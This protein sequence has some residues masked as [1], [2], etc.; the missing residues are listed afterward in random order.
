MHTA[1]NITDILD[2]L[3]EAQYF[4]VLDLASGFQ[5]IETHPE[6]RV[7]TAFST[8]QGNFEYLRMPIGIKNAPA[9]F[10]RLTDAVLK[11]MHGTEVF[12]YLDDMVVHSKDLEEHDLKI[13]R[14]LYRLRAASQKLQPDKCE[15]LQKEVAYLGH[16]IGQLGLNPNPAKVEAIK[17]CPRPKPERNIRQFL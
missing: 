9:I 11:G 16:I 17:N 13:R 6:D 5:Q 15:F 1:P 4:S 8:P 3:G 14:L 2:H 12:V 7:R 10:Q